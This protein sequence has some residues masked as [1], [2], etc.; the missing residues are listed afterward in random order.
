[1]TVQHAIARLTGEV[2]LPYVESGAGDGIPVV[3]L[4]AYADSWRSF[5]SVLS[6][7]PWSVR[8]LAPTQR[9]HG[10]A[11]KPIAG[12]AVADFA[13]D[14]V[15][16]LDELELG[17][18]ALVASSS[19][20][21]TALRV[22]ADVP[23]RVTGLVLIGAPWSLRERAPSL[24]FLEAVY[25]LEEPVDPAFVRD[26]VIGTS[27]ER[28]PLPFLETMIEESL[29]VPAYVWKETLD[30]LLAAPGAA[31]LAPRVPTLIVWGDQDE[32]LSMD[33]QVRLNSAIPGS[34]LVVYEGAGHAV[35]WE[36]P[37]RVAHDVSSFVAE[38]S[39]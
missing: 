2:E 37:E 3:F 7:L 23:D 38:L 16:F 27:S 26:F 29:K 34:R 6:L 35:H 30:G 15:A 33:D 5:E 9:G 10:D 36:L 22:A 11:T 4:H 18:A 17:R 39:R 8:A 25:A 13:R 12:Y 14:L 19:A 21:F 1:V 32:L 20:A 31:D 24:G 28:V